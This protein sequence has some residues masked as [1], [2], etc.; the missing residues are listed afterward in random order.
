MQVAP[1]V[2]I[3]GIDVT[4]EIDDLITGGIDKLEQVCDY[5]IST[6]I[7]IER[8]QQRHETGNPYRMRI[9]IRIPNRADIVVNRQS[10]SHKR[11]LFSRDELKAQQGIESEE[12]LEVVQSNGAVGRSPIPKKKPEEPLAAL[13]RRTF[14]TAQRELRKE[15]EK[16]RG[17]VKRPVQLD[18]MAVVE[19]LFPEQEYG[20]LRTP[21]G[22]QVYFHKN[23]VLH[24][25]WDGLAPGT[26]VRY[27]PQ[28][29]IEGLQASSIEILD[30][31]G[32]R[33]QHDT[34]H[35]LG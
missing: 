11:E 21:D 2:S 7:A 17:D 22:Q 28:E 20:F 3:K 10:T 27:T 8:E 26:M 24:R 5:I 34:L 31:P 25:H 15:V 1:E 13:I 4:A 9:D 19:K 29:G 33:E 32:I 18:S 14:A 6:R 23:G 12:E 35:P 30:K 16:Q